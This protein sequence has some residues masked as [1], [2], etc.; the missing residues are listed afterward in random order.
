MLRHQPALHALLDPFCGRAS[1]FARLEHL[2]IAAVDNL[3][4]ATMCARTADDVPTLMM[5]PERAKH[6]D[7]PNNC[8]AEIM[9]PPTGPRGRSHL[10][11]CP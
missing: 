3:P 9:R 8:P 11:Q 7:A 6:R 10:W 2:E 5:H 4:A 1:L